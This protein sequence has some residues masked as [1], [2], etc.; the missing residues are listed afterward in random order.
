METNSK[1]GNSVKIFF[2]QENDLSALF[3]F[4]KEHERNLIAKEI[5]GAVMQ[6]EKALMNARLH[7]SK[8]S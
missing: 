1:T 5:K 3:F 4:L 2:L 6:N 7:V 8:L